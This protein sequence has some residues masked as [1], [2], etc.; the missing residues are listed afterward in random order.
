MRGGATQPLPKD[1]EATELRTDPTIEPHA[2]VQTVE[3][4][5]DLHRGSEARESRKR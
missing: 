5:I 4:K 3:P 2:R 1:K